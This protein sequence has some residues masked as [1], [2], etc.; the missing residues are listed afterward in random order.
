[1]EHARS[2]NLS[3]TTMCWAQLF[4]GECTLWVCWAMRR[5]EDAAPQVRDLYPNGSGARLARYA[6]TVHTSDLRGAGEGMQG[7]ASLAC[8]SSPSLHSAPP[9]ATMSLC[10]LSPLLLLVQGLSA[11]R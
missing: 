9:A 7:P 1:M 2:H 6:L 8:Q 4:T 5:L 11:C 3:A 10:L